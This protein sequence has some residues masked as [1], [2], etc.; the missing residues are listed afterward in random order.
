MGDPFDILGLEPRFDLDAGAIRRAY[1]ARVAAIHPDSADAGAESERS[2]AAL[3]DAKGILESP[4]RRANVLLARLGGPTSAQDKT[5][6]S[7]FLLETMEMRER[8]EAALESGDPE[9]RHAIETDAG[10]LRAAHVARVA[11]LFRAAG[12]TPAPDSLRAIRVELNAWRYVE[13]LIEQ[14]EPSYDPNH[15]EFRE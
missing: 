5:L 15:A 13:R 6:P 12:A 14:L 2:S 1:L 9:A 4:E 8:I 3:N 10:A 7:G 11:A